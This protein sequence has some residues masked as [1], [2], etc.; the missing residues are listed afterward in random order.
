MDKYQK[1]KLN[2]IKATFWTNGIPN[3]KSKGTFNF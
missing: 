1:F 3:S 2:L